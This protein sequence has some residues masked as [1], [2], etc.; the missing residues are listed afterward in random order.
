[1]W[2][3]RNVL[4]VVLASIAVRGCSREIDSR[5]L[6]GKYSVT[7][8][9]QRQVLDLRTDGS[10]ENTFYRDGRLVWSL[11]EKWSYEVSEDR[12]REVVTFSRFKFGVAGYSSSPMGFWPV[13]PERAFSGAIEFCFDPNLNDRCF[14]KASS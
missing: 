4:M 3:T 7:I 11:T 10:Y 13:E 2:S 5:D 12:D 9:G 14:I 6:P 1:M 8:D